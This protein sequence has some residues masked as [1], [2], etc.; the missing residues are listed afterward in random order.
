MV[1]RTVRFV[2]APIHVSATGLLESDMNLW[3]LR[4]ETPDKTGFEFLNAIREHD[5]LILDHSQIRKFDAPNNLLLFG[6]VVFEGS[7]VRYEPFHPKPALTS[8]TV[9]LRMSMEGADKDNLFLMTSPPLEPLRFVVEN[10]GEQTVRDFRTT[11]LIPT[12][13]VRTSSDSTLG[14]LILSGNV[15]EIEGHP[16]CVYGNFISEPIYKNERVRIG[17]LPLKANYGQYSFFW[18]I[19]CDEGAFP[20]ETHYRRIKIR[21]VPLNDLVKHTEE[22]LGNKP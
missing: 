20:S 14:N 19:R 7:T 12:A 16:Y 5:P 13:F 1:D 22:S 21:V 9:N 4:R 8:I 15:V 3:I 2:P 6:Q 18:K 11:V 17:S 10:M